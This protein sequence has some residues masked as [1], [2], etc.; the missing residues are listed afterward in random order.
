MTQKAPDLNASR[1]LNGSRVPQAADDTPVTGWTKSDSF[2]VAFQLDEKFGPWTAAYKIRWRNVTDSGSFADLA[3]T[4]EMKWATDT[5]L[6]NGNAVLIG[7]KACTADPGGTWEDGEEIEGDYLTESI[8]LDDEDYT[9]IH[10]AITGADGDDGDQYE[11]EIYDDSN[12]AA[13]GT[14][15]ASLTLKSLNPPV[16]AASRLLNASRSPLAAD[17]TDVTGYDKSNEFIV[18]A[19][20]DEEEGPWNAQYMLRWRD[21]TDSGSFAELGATGEMKR[22]TATVLVNGDAVVIGEKACTNTPSGSTW[23]DGEEVEGASTCDAINLA[24]EYYTEIHFAVNPADADDLHEYEFELYDYTNSASIGTL[25]ATIKTKLSGFIE[26]PNADIADWAAVLETSGGDIYVV[27]ENTSGNLAVWKKQDGSFSQ[28]DSDTPTTAFGGGTGGWCHAT[29]DSNDDIHIVWVCESDQTRDIAYCVFDTGT[30]TLGGWEEAA[31]FTSGVPTWGRAWITIDA[32]DRPWVIYVDLVG[33]YRQVYSTYKD[34]TWQTPER[35]NDSTSS[36][37]YDPRICACPN[38]HFEAIYYGPGSDLYYNHRTTSW[39]TESSYSK[40]LS[41]YYA[42]GVVLSDTGDN[43]YRIYADG[44]GSPCNVEENGTDTGYDVDDVNYRRVSASLVGSTRYVFF[45]EVTSYDLHLIS[46]DGGGWTDE[47]D[48]LTAFDMKHV[49]A[50]W[51]Y[52]NNNQSGHINYIVSDRAG[53][54]IVYFSQ[55]EVAAPLTKIMGATLGLSEA[56]VRRA[57]SVRPVPENEGISD[58]PIRRLW[59]VRPFG[60]S[61]GLADASLRKASLVRL[62]AETVGIIEN[63]VKVT[64]TVIVKLM[65]ETVGL[66]EAALRRMWSVRLKAETLGISESPLRRLGSIRQIAETVSLQDAAI[67]RMWS[68]RIKA[69]SVSL[70]DTA[71]KVFAIIKQFAE[72]VGIYDAM[73]K[74]AGMVRV[75]SETVGIVENFVKVTVSTIVKVMATETIGLSEALLRRMWSIWQM[76]ETI[77]LSDT[78]IKRAWMVRLMA[79]TVGLLES[80]VRRMQSVKEMASTVGINEAGLLYKWFVKIISETVGLVEGWIKKLTQIL[81]EVDVIEFWGPITKEVDIESRFTDE[82]EFESGITKDVE[83]DARLK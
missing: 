21:V 3:A 47:G 28:V 71:V 29:I 14:A 72:T 16:L 60:E 37:Y 69:E 63:F 40:S 42:V 31:P 55:L 43:Q 73:L 34:G 35:V 41:D 66:T 81:R 17:D 82:M 53:T 57:W 70:Q 22:G 32:S 6:Q 2:I 1:I 76:A 39:G 12:G 56:Q 10:V 33:S 11:F 4:G 75:A 19:Q 51:H 44:T 79:S 18:V 49:I 78:W 64:F 45:P 83:L 20:I 58:A 7:E 5:D 24:D 54:E 61:V 59:S 65:T 26:V 77:S 30:D 8:A 23:Q 38:G 15:L 9:E 80:I 62:M 25:L 67:R 36:E 46:N 13:V 52:H 50:E 27:S 48:L 68:I 74:V